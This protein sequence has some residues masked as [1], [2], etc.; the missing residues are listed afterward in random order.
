M[1]PEEYARKLLPPEGWDYHERGYEPEIDRLT[2]FIATII[3]EER[4]ACARLVEEKDRRDT[5]RTGIGVYYA[6]GS[7]DC[8]KMATVTAL[9]AAIRARTP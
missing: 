4:E 6:C 1:T 7:D 2:A 5:G 9:A 3:A 8:C